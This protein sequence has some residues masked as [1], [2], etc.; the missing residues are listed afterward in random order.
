MPTNDPRPTKAVRRDEARAKAAQMRKEQERKAKRNRILAISGL[1]VAVLALV[2]VAFSILKQNKANEAAN[3]NVAYG[4]GT[5]ERGRARRS[6]TSPRPAPPTTPAGSPSA[7]PAATTS[8][9]SVTTTSTSRSTSTSCAPTAASSTRPT[10]AT[11]TRSLGGG[12]RDHHVPPGLDPRPHA[13]RAARTRRVR[14]TPTAIVADQVA[15]ALHR[16]RHRAVQGPAGRGHLGPDRR[17]DRQDRQGPRRPGR[18]D[19]RPSPTRSTAPSTPRTRR[20]SRARGGRSP[21]GRRRHQP[22]RHRPAEFSTPTVLIDGEPF[23][24]GRHPAP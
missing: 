5:R 16:L 22:G 21:R 14:S 4:Q 20:A 3:S 8:A 18:G 9:R 7:A 11:S 10:P 23:E 15:G 2:A 13:P 1:V 19:R 17:R 6:T 24:D 12:R